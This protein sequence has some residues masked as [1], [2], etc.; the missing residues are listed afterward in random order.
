L[1]FFVYYPK[2][3]LKKY[4]DRL[5]N[6]DY[7]QFIRQKLLDCIALSKT[8]SQK[9]TKSKIRKTLPAPFAYII[10]ELLFES[11]HIKDKANYYNA[12][13]DAIFKTNREQNF[14]IELSYFIQRLTIDR[15]HVVGDIFDRGP[16]AH[17]VLDKMMKYH[18]LDIEWGNHDVLWM[19]AASGSRLAICNVLRN[20]AKYNTLDTL[21]EGYGINLLPLAS[22][23]NKTYYDD[24]CDNFIPKTQH[25][26]DD[27]KKALVAKIHKAITIMQ[28]KLEHL[29]FQRNPHFH[30]EDHCHLHHINYTNGTV[31]LNDH[32]YAL[33]DTHFP[34]IDP[35]HPYQ[36][37]PQEET[38]LKQLKNAFL[39]NDLLQNHVRFLFQKGQMYL[40]YNNNLLFHGCIPLDEDGHFASMMI[41]DTLVKGKSLLDTLEQKIRK[42][43]LNRYQKENA[44]KDYFIFLWQGKNSPLFGKT[45]MKTFE[46]Y[47]ISDKNAHQEP[48]NNYFHLRE[49]ETILKNI[50]NEFNID[51]N[52]SKIINGHVPTDISNGESPVKANGR[53]YAI[54]GGMS[55]QYKEKIGIGGYT[56]IADS[57]KLFLI[58]H[59]RFPSVETLIE[60][61]TDIISLLQAEDINLEREYIYNTDKG[62]KIKADINDLTVLLEAYRSGEIK[63]YIKK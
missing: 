28:F 5:P 10:Q 39:N 33:K 1:A 9:Y 63:E 53:I 52:H 50:Y 29:V 38:V 47:L 8:M 42:A 34:T 16:A 4:Q 45:Q 36:L 22:F 14:L 60:K 3:M 56:L 54:D 27:D 12:I 59:E 25:T 58:S 26:I 51:Y 31:T 11:T 37:T 62:K 6:Q 57:Y 30:L 23:A 21:E 18:S 55:S 35:E 61:E 43:Y 49:D 7:K 20:S 32:T 15:L 17:L 19:G 40:K 2:Q 48:M 44:D 46:R 24:A 41:D 13:L